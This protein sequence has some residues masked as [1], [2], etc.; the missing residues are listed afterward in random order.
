MVNRLMEAWQHGGSVEVILVLTIAGI[1][2]ASLILLL[3][4]ISRRLYNGHK[5]RILDEL[6]HRYLP[7][8]REMALAGRTSPN[9]VS[10]MRAKP[11]SAKWIALEDD[12]FLLLQEDG[13][14]SSI[15]PLFEQLGYVEFYRRMLDRR[16]PITQA[17]GISKLGMIKDTHS[18]AQLLE[19]MG[20]KDPE[21]VAASIRAFCEIGETTLFPR[22]FGLLP[23]LLNKKSVTMKIIETSLAMAGEAAI[24]ALVQSGLRCE[25]PRIIASILKVL[26]DASTDKIVYAFAQSKIDHS[27]PEVRAKA[28]KIIANSDHS[29]GACSH[30]R[31]PQLL[32]DP[33]W[34]VRLQAV[35]AIGKQRCREFV[36]EMSSL[37]LDE[38]WQ[39]RNA[40]AEA[41]TGLGEDAIEI[42]LKILKS[43]DTYAKESICEVMQKTGFVE[44]LLS[45]L[46]KGH[47]AHRSS[48]YEIFTI[49]ASLG[50]TSQLKDYLNRTEDRSV[51]AI[52]DLAQHE[53]RQEASHVVEIPSRPSSQRIQTELRTAS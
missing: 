24:P 5:Y 32:R 37:V 44:R 9:D 45:L 23:N 51:A 20:K 15:V 34:F 2:L 10:P 6:R 48:M 42:F 11:R 19:M 27:D 7:L 40:A 38:K 43:S 46:E 12:L 13:I 4:S 53:A 33:V 16:S 49:M 3:T 8:L 50:F 1:G 39:V 41:L 35:R 28:L 18:A 21:I 36:E 31:W 47:T 25:D 26:G 30:E 29:W 52:I 22:F 14:R 17:A